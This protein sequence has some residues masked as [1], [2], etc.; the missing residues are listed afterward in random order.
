MN[1]AFAQTMDRIWQSYGDN[2]SWVFTSHPT[3]FGD[4]YA[5]LAVFHNFRFRNRGHIQ[6]KLIVGT[7]GHLAIARMF[8]HLFDAIHHVP[9]LATV[10]AQEMQEWSLARRKFHFAPGN[11]IWLHP[12]YY[13]FPQYEIASLMNRGRANYSEL[14]RLGLRLPFE[15]AAAPPVTTEAM[16]S[17]AQQLA[18][19]HGIAPGKT[20]LLFP[21]SRSIKQDCT[22]HF[23]ALADLAKREGY[24]V[25]TSVAGAEQ[26]IAGTQGVSI[27]FDL[28]I[29]YCELAGRVVAARSGVSDIISNAECFKLDLYSFDSHLDIFSIADYELGGSSAEVIFPFSDRSVEDFLALYPRVHEATPSDR[30]NSIPLPVTRYLSAHRA[31]TKPQTAIGDPGYVHMFGK[32]RAVGG[33]VLGTGWSGIEPW[34]V[35]STGFRA[36]LYLGNPYARMSSGPADVQRVVVRLDLTAALNERHTTHRINILLGD[37]H[38]SYEFIA[39]R[40]HPQVTL[41]VPRGLAADMCLKVVIEIHT[42]HSPT[43]NSADP[44][45]LGIGLIGVAFALD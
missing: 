1:D 37:N 38:Y 3:Q 32:Y 24:R 21:Y 16:R 19:Q 28:L 22:A 43:L 17:S 41:V 2:T 23:A 10:P 29:P 13:C 35:W 36:F 27:P 44:R 40:P 30:F 14:C 31:D 11:L 5:C 7:P 33:V 20:I 4:L 39:G 26:P 12:F 18:V 45:L 34:G 9:E 15:L 42:P 25:F 6:I 8:G